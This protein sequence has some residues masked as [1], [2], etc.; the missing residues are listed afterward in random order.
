MEYLTKKELISICKER[1]IPG[2]SGKNKEEIYEIIYRYT[3]GEIQDTGKHR[4]NGKDQ[5]YT[6]EAVAVNCIESIVAMVP[7]VLKYLWLEPSAG[8]G[9]FLH[10]TPKEVEKIGIDVDPKSQEILREDF[11][12]WKTISEK[13]IL[14]FGNPPFGR[15]SS[16]AKAFIKKSCTFATVIAFILPKSFTKPSMSNVFT[17]NFHCI[18]SIELD[19]NSFLI[20]GVKYDVPCVFQIWK[21]ENSDR[22]IEQKIFP[23][24]FQYVKVEQKYDVAFRRVGS[25]AGKCYKNNGLNYNNQSHYF[26]KFDDHLIPQMESIIEKINQHIFPSNTVGPRSLSKSEINSVINDIVKQVSS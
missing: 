24:R 2:Y 10:N 4:I 25:N 16:L 20:N 5:F 13:E 23:N 9:S 14:V 8:N 3:E 26:L 19:K 15:Q 11:M 1:K 6:A 22:C 18:H 17:L 12:N 7:E 21:R